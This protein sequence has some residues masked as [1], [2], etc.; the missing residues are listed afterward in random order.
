MYEGRRSS[1]PEGVFVNFVCNSENAEVSPGS[2]A[3]EAG[4]Q[5]A[6]FAVVVATV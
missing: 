3:A 5:V 2:P 1:S 4:L 6:A